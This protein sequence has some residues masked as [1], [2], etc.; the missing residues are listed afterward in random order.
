M[1]WHNMSWRFWA[2]RVLSLIDGPIYFGKRTDLVNKRT[3]KL[4]T[5]DAPDATRIIFLQCTVYS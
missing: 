5:I 1:S 4:Y 3:Q 2:A